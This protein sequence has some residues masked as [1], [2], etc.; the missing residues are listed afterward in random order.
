MLIQFILFPI[1]YTGHPCM[2][3]LMIM[4]LPDV[5]NIVHGQTAFSN[6]FRRH[7]MRMKSRKRNLNPSMADADC[8]SISN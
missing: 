6:D 5:L 3:H 4:L 7:Q 8:F 1:N 2:D